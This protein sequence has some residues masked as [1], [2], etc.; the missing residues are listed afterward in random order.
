MTDKLSKEIESFQTLWK[1]GFRT[2]RRP[3]RNQADIEKFLVS[4]LKPG[5]T[6]LEIGCGGGQWSKVISEKVKKLHCVD[7]LSAEYNC[8]WK[9]VG[10][11]QDVITYHHVNDFSLSS[12]PMQSI[13][14]VFSYDVFCHISLTGIDSYLKSIYSKCK[15]GAELMIMYADIDK[16][17]KTEPYNLRSVSNEYLLSE[18]NDCDGFARPGRWY[19]VGIDNFKTLIDKYKYTIITLDMDIDKTNPITFF[20]KLV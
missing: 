16:Y 18:K 8:F 13:D 15:P 4:Y 7:V 20:K 12:I 11:K 2:G 19:W 14:F 17:V 6:V 10:N 5:M 9:Y 1:G 3:N